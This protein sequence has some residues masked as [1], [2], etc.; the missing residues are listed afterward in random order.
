MEHELGDCLWEGGPEGCVEVSRLNELLSRGGLYQE[1]EE[2]RVLDGERNCV[3]GG[4]SWKGE[5]IPIL[6]QQGLVMRE[7]HG[8]D[9]G[10]VSTVSQG[11]NY[12]L[13]RGC[14]ARRL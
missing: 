7:V 13:R 10:K 4:L 2:E 11:K 5:R 3:G 14:A 9:R 1:E 12:C 6:H 8:R